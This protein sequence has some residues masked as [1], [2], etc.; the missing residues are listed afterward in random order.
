MSIDQWIAAGVVVAFLVA[1]AVAR[2]W[3]NGGSK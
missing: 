3:F 2:I 1:Y